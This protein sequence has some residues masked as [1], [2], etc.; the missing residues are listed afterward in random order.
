MNDSTTSDN[1]ILRGLGLNPATLD[2]HFN[3]SMKPVRFRHVESIGWGDRWQAVHRCNLETSNGP[4]GVVEGF[5]FTADK[6][7]DTFRKLMKTWE[8][9]WLNDGHS[10]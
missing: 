6:N 7:R 4:E 10:Y 5:E 9:N 2:S 1:T 3:V 8:E